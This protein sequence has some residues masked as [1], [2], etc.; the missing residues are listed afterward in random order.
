MRFSH[1]IN[2]R[3][4][5]EALRLMDVSRS[6]IDAHLPDKK[7][8]ANKRASNDPLDISAK[9]YSL[10]RDLSGEDKSISYA[11]F[12]LMHYYRLE[13]VRERIRGRG[14]KDEELQRCLVEFDTFN[15]WRISTDGTTLQFI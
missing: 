15:V 3:D 13:M 10:V 1:E 4:I 2:Q 8:R 6:T 14:F 5:D 9:I 7:K 12:E 11:I